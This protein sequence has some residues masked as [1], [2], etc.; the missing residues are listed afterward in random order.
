[1][2]VGAGVHLGAGVHSGAGVESITVRLSV[3]LNVFV[4]FLSPP[5]ILCTTKSRSFS[6]DLMAYLAARS[7]N[8]ENLASVEIDGLH[9]LVLQFRWSIR[10]KATLNCAAVIRGFLATIA[11]HCI[12]SAWDLMLFLFSLIHKK[13]QLGVAVC[14]GPQDKSPA[15][16]I[17]LYLVFVADGLAQNSG[18][19]AYS[20]PLRVVYANR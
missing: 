4:L 12:F 5:L 20:V 10:Q 7:L 8:P 6:S 9:C 18:P 3:N 14:A 19:S 1:V 15:T 2:N 16:L 13:T 17:G 11:S